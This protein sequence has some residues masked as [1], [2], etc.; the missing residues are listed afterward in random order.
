MEM[1][2]GRGVCFGLKQR[3]VRKETGKIQAG[4]DFVLAD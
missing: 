2:I 4:F 3:Y 1:V